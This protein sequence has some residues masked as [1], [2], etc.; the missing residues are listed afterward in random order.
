MAISNN[1][2]V[3]VSSNSPSGVGGVAD[4]TKFMWQKPHLKELK[5]LAKSFFI[6]ETQTSF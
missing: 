4:D 6:W 1:N 3:K 5:N 2:S